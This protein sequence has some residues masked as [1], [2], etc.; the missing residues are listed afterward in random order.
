MHFDLLETLRLL[1]PYAMWV[2]IFIVFAESGLFVGFFLPGDSLLFSA[3]VL[4][5]QGFMPI[6]VL[7]I[8]CFLAA[9][10]GVSVGYWFGKRFGRD[11]FEKE[12]LP[13]VK[14]HHLEAAEKFY[15]KH[16]RKTII[17][18]RFVPIVRTFAPIA[19]GIAHMDYRT[20]IS[21]NIIGGLIWAVGMTLGGY[22]LGS[23]IPADKIDKYLLPIIMAIVVISLLPALKHI[24]DEKKSRKKQSED[25]A[26]HLILP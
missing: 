7:S 22:F 5:S 13:L 1:G 6:G 23:F 16:G 19:A 2:V 9:T 24:L 12:K 15:A 4:A 18:A 11:I 20:F 25:P 3:G 21:Y 8:G 10:I 26:D 17:L 14:K